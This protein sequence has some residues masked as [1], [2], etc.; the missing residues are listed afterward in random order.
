[1]SYAERVR[2]AAT[3]LAKTLKQAAETQ[4]QQDAANLAYQRAVSFQPEI[5]G[6]LHCPECWIQYGSLAPL[7]AVPGV[8]PG[9][10]AF[11]CEGCDFKL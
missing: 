1:M 7:V 3:G 5:G 9:A 10:P 2:A 6:M 8:A 4:E 11:R